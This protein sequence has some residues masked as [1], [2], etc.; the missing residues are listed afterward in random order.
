MEKIQYHTRVKG[1]KQE[2]KTKIFPLEKIWF[3][4]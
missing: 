4:S 3:T 1:K 2:E